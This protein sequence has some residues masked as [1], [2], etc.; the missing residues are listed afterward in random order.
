MRK[1]QDDIFE[2]WR[3]NVGALRYFGILTFH[4][5]PGLLAKDESLYVD[6]KLI[7]RAENDL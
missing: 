2:R 5:R 3:I 1:P 4:D 6:G 7:V